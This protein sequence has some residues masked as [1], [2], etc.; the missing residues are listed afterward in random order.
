[1]IFKRFSHALYVQLLILFFCLLG[2]VYFILTPGYYA[3]SML[4]ALMSMAACWALQRL[5]TKH[6]RQYTR[7]L[8]A[9]N[10]LDFDN[11]LPPAP[12]DCSFPELNQQLEKLLY[13]WQEQLQR[14]A[15]ELK[16]CQAM[17]EHMPI[18]LISIQG[19][20][21]VHFHNQSA[22]RF[23]ELG[24]FCKA[25]DL[26]RFGEDFYYALCH[27]KP[28]QQQLLNF[29]DGRQTRQLSV[30]T[31]LY[32]SNKGQEILISLMDIEAELDRNQLQAWRE[33]AS[34]LSHELLNSITPVASL[35]ETS[36]TLLE[37][38]RKGIM[39]DGSIGTPRASEALDDAYE[40][41]QVLARRAKGL[42]DFVSN[43][44]Q[45]QNTAEIKPQIFTLAELFKE[46]NT[47]LLA[48]SSF[49]NIELQFETE[50]A[51]LQLNADRELL[52]Q[53]LINLMK[54]SAQ[55]MAEQSNQA[56]SGH[57]I[58]VSAYLDR[59][60]RCHVEVLDNGPGIKAEHQKRIFLPFY[61]SKN[62][63]SGIGLA[64]ARQTMVAHGGK[65]SVH[66]GPSGG[67]LFRLSF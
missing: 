25:G 43:Y 24:D 59:R 1:M 51:S 31:S 44:R 60:N 53:L 39:S 6:N 26:R 16:H 32:K 52:E 19:E 36:Q 12:I 9:A 4:M 67:A 27:L 58:S 38:C 55:A 61:T 21:T 42:M 64:M 57:R 66:D 29:Y 45:L 14:Q 65:I 30:Q 54:N 20:D 37:D 15:L 34:V 13:S 10:H 46:L 5:V 18:P 11:R 47:L 48:D 17:I 41:S 7:L 40:A 22:R 56:S 8:Q 28:G 23:F 3:V 62:D 35:A 63:G 2:L 49:H 50:P 33:M